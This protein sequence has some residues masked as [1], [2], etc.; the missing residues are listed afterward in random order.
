VKMAMQSKVVAFS[1]CSSAPSLTGS[2]KYFFRDYPAD[3]YQGKFAA[4]YIYQKLGARKVAILYHITDW[5]TGLK[6]VFDQEFQKLG[7]TILDVEGFPQTATDYRSQLSKIKTLNPDV[8]YSPLYSDGSIAALTQA[9]E[10]G[11]KTT[12]FGGDAWDD[13]NLQQKLSGQGTFLYTVFATPAMPQDLQQKILAISGGTSIPE[14][15]PT[16]Y[17][18]AQVL[19]AALA[20]G[21]TNPDLLATALRATSYDGISGHIAFDQNGDLTTAAY[22]VKQFKNGGAVQISQ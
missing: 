11:M 8:I 18:A 2:G 19:A 10:L 7:G 21:G 6:D 22:I 5:S 13:P 3:S 14:C 9:H 16:A 15:A 12:F 4:D 1:Y 17:P 20:K